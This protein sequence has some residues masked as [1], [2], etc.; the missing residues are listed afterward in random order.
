MKGAGKNGYA[1]A[2]LGATGVVGRAM[3]KTLER[4]NFP[5]SELRLF[6]TER[7]AGSRIMFR[8]EE[9]E[10]QDARSGDFTGIDISLFSAGT[11]AARTYANVAMDY[12]AVVIDNSSAFR[13]EPWVPLVVPEVNPEAINGHGGLISNPNCSTIQLTVA[14][15]PLLPLGM[16]HVYVSTYQAAS[17]MGQRGISGLLDGS[18][19]DATFPTPGSPRHYPLALNVLPQCDDFVDNGY[20]KEE[21]KIINESRKI[22]GNRDL[23]ISPTAVRVPVVYGHSESVAIRFNSPVSLSEIKERLSK[24]P[25]IIVIDDPGNGLF[26]HPR[27]AEGSGEVYVGRIRKDITD[28]NT[29]LMFVVADNI[30]KGA[31]WNAVQIAELLV[32]GTSGQSDRTQRGL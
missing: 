12:G 25:G 4:R 18:G 17:G 24:A 6:A 21:M 32:K 15:K 31:A 7:S 20:T 11:E 30:L 23:K 29:I 2:V 3:V 19:T 26:P 5:V 13:M 10:V 14:I 28:P 27:L 8:G 9:T 16:D 1:V 22:L